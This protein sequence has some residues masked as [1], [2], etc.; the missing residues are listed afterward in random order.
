[1]SG[2]SQFHLLGQYPMNERMMLPRCTLAAQSVRHDKH[3]PNVSA[4]RVLRLALPFVCLSFVSIGFALRS[5]FS[6][7]G[8]FQVNRYI[9]IRVDNHSV[10]VF[11]RHC[12]NIRW[13]TE[14]TR[15]GLG[16]QRMTCLDPQASGTGNTARSAS[17]LQGSSAWSSWCLCGRSCY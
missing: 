7:V 12:E 11:R 17:H 14:R 13:Q 10:I 16:E 5:S 15:C 1:M 3:A 2:D 9:R 8:G 4:Y 6:L